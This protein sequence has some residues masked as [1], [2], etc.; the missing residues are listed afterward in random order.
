MARTSQLW[1]K[2]LVDVFKWISKE[3]IEC[4]VKNMKNSG[5]LLAVI[6][7]LNINK[8]SE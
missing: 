3:C 4:I 8:I 6:M 2:V 5:I 1:R 7:V